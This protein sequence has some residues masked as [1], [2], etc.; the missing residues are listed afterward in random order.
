MTRAQLWVQLAGT[1]VRIGTL[2]GHRGGRAESATLQ[3]D[4]GWVARPDSFDLDPTAPRGT[5][6]L[7]TPVGQPLFG[8]LQDCCPDRWGRTLLKQHEKRV[9]ADE[10]RE[11]RTLSEMDLLLG[12]RDDLRQGDLRLAL[13]GTGWQADPDEGVPALSA[14]G[15]LLELADRAQDDDLTRDELA[16]LVRQGSSLGGARPKSHVIDIDGRL[17]IAKF[18]SASLDTWDVMAWE[19]VALDL[20]ADA[21]IDVP[22]SR[23]IDI[24]GRHVLLVTRFDRILLPDGEH[25]RV[26][27][28]SAMT[29]CEHRD[30]DPASYLD[31]ADAIEGHSPHAEADLQ[32]LWRRMAFNVLITNVDDHLRNHAFLHAGGPTWRLS[33]A[34][35]LNPVPDAPPVLSTALDEGDATASVDRLL[36]VASWLRL[37]PGQALDV[38]A[39]V[40]AATSRWREVAT[41]HGLDER[42]VAAMARAFEHPRATAAAD[43]VG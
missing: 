33:P 6:T 42:A 27:Y 20:A 23:L 26:G 15:D 43:I 21:G 35:D 39:E 2:Y 36:A 38:L 24:A 17:A 31:V 1:D 12:V 28:R 16:R 30:G 11:L 10:G 29:M 34:F 19:K 37:D 14:L 18:P 8:A 5:G 40:L 9:A 3:Y 7:Q 22:D 13:D 4:P 25:R 41:S 32:Q